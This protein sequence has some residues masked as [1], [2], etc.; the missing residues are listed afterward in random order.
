MQRKQKGQGGLWIGLL[1][2]RMAGLVVCGGVMVETWWFL[3]AVKEG[4][5]GM[6][7]VVYVFEVF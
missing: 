3:E 5:M 6:V 2:I 7:F 1:G 4:L